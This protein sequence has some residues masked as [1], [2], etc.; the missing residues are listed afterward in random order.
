M[1]L[2]FE[3]QSE[4]FET[5]KKYVVVVVERKPVS[6]KATFTYGMDLAGKLPRNFRGCMNLCKRFREER[7]KARNESGNYCKSG[8][9]HFL[10]F[11]S[12]DWSDRYIR[13]Y[14]LFM[15][16]PPNLAFVMAF[17]FVPFS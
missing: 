5:I 16:F 14:V 12:F 3:S 4:F 6:F 8:I 15:G 10:I 13:G 1:D 17:L 7:D 2:R 9:V 11:F